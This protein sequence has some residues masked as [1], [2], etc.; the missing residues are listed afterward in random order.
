MNFYFRA[1]HKDV[2]FLKQ[3]PQEAIPDFSQKGANCQIK[4]VEVIPEYKTVIRF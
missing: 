2:P 1:L 4:N 3:L